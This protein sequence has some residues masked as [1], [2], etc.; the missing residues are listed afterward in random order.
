M[1]LQRIN[2][3]L[4]QVTVQSSNIVDSISFYQKLGLKLIVEN[5]NYAR[6]ECPNGNAT[7]SVHAI[8][9]PQTG[10]TVVYFEV[11]DLEDKVRDLESKGIRFNKPPTQEPW[12]WY[13]ATVIDPS[14]NEVCIYSAGDNRKNPP[15]RV[16]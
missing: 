11:N 8:G 12:L 13:E 15:W 16:G 1:C 7:F 4:N 2:M 5:D 9:T 3:D 10:N 6:F 14:G